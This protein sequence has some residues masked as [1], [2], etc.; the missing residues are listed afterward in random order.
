M[1]R[2][3]AL[4]SYTIAGWSGFYV[5]LVELLSGRPPFRGGT[6]LQVLNAVL[7]R[8]PPRLRELRRDAPRD[9]ETV[10]LKCL[11]KEPGRRYASAGELADDLGRF[12]AGE[13]IVARPAGKLERAWKWA[14]R[15]PAVAALS[16][17]VVTVTVVALVV[18]SVFWQNAV[19]R[20]S[21]RRIRSSGSVHRARRTR[22][23]V[24]GGSRPSAAAGPGFTRRQNDA[25]SCSPMSGSQPRRI[26]GTSSG[27]GTCHAVPA[28]N[29]SGAREARTV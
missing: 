9:L 14:R 23:T 4:W 18:V 20:I 8:E 24:V 27:W 28:R 16:A 6:A 7:H 17:A 22:R 10:C 2:P 19:A 21:K 29:G 11:S 5:M 13:P 12:L 1:A 3:H 15:R 26:A 25:K